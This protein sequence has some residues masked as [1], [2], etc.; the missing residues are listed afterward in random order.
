MAKVTEVARCGNCG[1]LYRK[2]GLRLV[3]EFWGPKSLCR[4][5]YQVYQYRQ[6]GYW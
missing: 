4:K 5:C 3:S 1:K 6:W 2:D